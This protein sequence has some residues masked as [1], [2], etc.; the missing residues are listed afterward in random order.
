MQLH[1]K[2]YHLFFYPSWSL[3]TTVSTA[4]SL[5]WCPTIVEQQ[6]CAVSCVKVKTEEV[7]VYG[8][9]SPG[10]FMT[11]QCVNNFTGE[12]KGRKEAREVCQQ[13]SCTYYATTSWDWS[14]ALTLKELLAVETQV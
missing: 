7:G 9:A 8:Y 4:A 10:S 13:V 14:Y 1:C 2:L 11:R 12:A 3:P 6:L 5:I